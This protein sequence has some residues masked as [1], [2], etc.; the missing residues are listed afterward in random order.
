MF[1]STV[2][3]VFFDSPPPKFRGQMSPP[4]FGGYG[5]SGRFFVKFF[6]CVFFCSCRS[7]VFDFVVAVEN[8]V[9]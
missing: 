4:E 5:S 9:I 7:I 1:E 6:L 2:K 3:Q 8:N